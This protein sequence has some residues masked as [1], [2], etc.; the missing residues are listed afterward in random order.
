MWFCACAS[1]HLDH[2]NFTKLLPNLVKSIIQNYF[3][4]RN[5]IPGSAVCLFNLTAINM[6]FNGP[7]KHQ[8]TI[9]SAWESKPN[10]H[11][12]QCQNHGRDTSYSYSSNF[13]LMDNAVQPMTRTPVYHSQLER[14]VHI[15]VDE[16]VAKR[17]RYV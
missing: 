14:I 6:A 9:S 4:L 1:L 5:S 11:L 16:L 17:Q 3:S 8:Q 2:L 15:A 7:Y 12:K 13:Q 10:D